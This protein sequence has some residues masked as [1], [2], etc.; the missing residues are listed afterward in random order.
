MKLLIVL[1]LNITILTLSVELVQ[2]R[3]HS[4]ALFG[5]ASLI[6]NESDY[7]KLFNVLSHE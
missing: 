7:S 4:T 6:S 3:P 2:W 1:F 5:L